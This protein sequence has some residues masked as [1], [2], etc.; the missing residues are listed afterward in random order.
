MAGQERMTIEQVVRQVLCDEQADV[1]RAA[2]EA[3]CAELMEVEVA[4]QIGDSRVRAICLRP[5]DGLVRGT[6]VRNTGAG[7]QMPVGDAVLGQVADR[8]RGHFRTEDTTGRLGGDEF[9]VIIEDG[10][11]FTQ[12]LL[13]RLR[14]VLS[15]PYGFRG[16][17]I[18]VTVSVGMASPQLG[19]TS[20][21]LLERADRTMYLAKAANHVGI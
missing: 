20:E 15:A 5:T 10:S 8:L 3:V 18:L 1:L 19:E 21:Q 4:Q 17:P 7:M 11:S 14:D 9:A 13:D 2:V 6:A 16:E 12:L